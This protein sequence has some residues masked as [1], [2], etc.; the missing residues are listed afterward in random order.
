MTKLGKQSALSR[1]AFLVGMAGTAVT[2]G[3]APGRR[4]REGVG[5]EPLRTHDLVQP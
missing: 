1:R 5:V 4:H 3:F 2:F